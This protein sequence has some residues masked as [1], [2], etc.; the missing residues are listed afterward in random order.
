MLCN[1]VIQKYERDIFRCS[2]QE[3]SGADTE[4]LAPL[5][6]VVDLDTAHTHCML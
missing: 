5:T 3:F 2:L 6:I 4:N 1:Y